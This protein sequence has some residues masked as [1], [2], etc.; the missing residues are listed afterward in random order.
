MSTYVLVHGAWHGSWC[1][2]K[3]ASLLKQTGH[4]VETLDL[5]GHGQDKTPLGEITLAA[6]T[7]RVGETLDAQAEPV[8]LVGHSLGGIVITQVAEE[9]PEKIQR[10]VYLA[11]FL[12]QNGESLFQV[13]QTDSDSL[14][15]PNLMVNEEQGSVT[16]K[17]GAP[18]KDMFYGDCSDEDVARATSLLV[19]QAL[20]P[21]ATP[22]RITAEHFGRVPRVYIECLRDRAISPSIQK[23]MYTATPCQTIMSMETS[24]S[25]FFSAPQELVQ[26]LTSLSSVSS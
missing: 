12:V 25:P 15:A 19:P 2:E 20:A 7:K 1:W 13:A 21:L 5:P 11:A 8:I 6:Y 18:L 17:E 23:R 26:H 4:Q 16:F 22:V 9:R 3:V 24:H 14:V 10:L